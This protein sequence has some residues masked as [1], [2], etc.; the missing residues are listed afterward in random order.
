M[1]IFCKMAGIFEEFL[2]L[3]CCVFFLLI[4]YNF[5]LLFFL[6]SIIS[7]DKI[8]HFILNFPTSLPVTISNLD[9][10]LQKKLLTTR[11][12]TLGIVSNLDSLCMSSITVVPYTWDWRCVH[13]YI[14][15]HYQHL[16]VQRTA[17]V[18][19]TTSANVATSYSLFRSSLFFL[20]NT[21]NIVYPIK[22]DCIFKFNLNR[23]AS[24]Y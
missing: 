7:L 16:L 22:I 23:V 17:S 13:Q 8:P 1:I 20:V 15:Q 19:K 3:L 2:L 10:V 14:E 4:K 5:L 18:H 21:L 9:H 11:Q 24:T 12:N 6:R